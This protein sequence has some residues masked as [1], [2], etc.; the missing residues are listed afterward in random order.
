MGTI[1]LESFVNDKTSGGSE[2]RFT[3]KEGARHHT[4]WLYGDG[5]S[6][7]HPKLRVDFTGCESTEIGT[8]L[9]NIANTLGHIAATVADTEGEKIVQM[10][11][12]L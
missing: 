9:Q 7:W 3:I 2:V 10:M 4:L 8:V 12:L 1:K 5:D 6:H 11:K